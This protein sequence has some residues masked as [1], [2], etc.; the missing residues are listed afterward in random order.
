[1]DIKE[2]IVLVYSGAECWYESF[3]HGIEEESVPIYCIAA[4][5]EEDIKEYDALA[6]ATFASKYSVFE[7]GVG[8]DRDNIVIRHRLQKESAPLLDVSRNN[9]EEIIR[10]QGNNVARIVKKLPLIL[11]DERLWKQRS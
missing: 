3:L 7:I 2:G 6:M 5:S 9:D 1:M 10:L 8:V 4:E 11:D